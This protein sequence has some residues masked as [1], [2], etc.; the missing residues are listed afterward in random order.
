[1]GQG[2]KL[3]AVRAR[4]LLLHPLL[5]PNPTMS[6]LLLLLLLLWLWRS[7]RLRLLVL[8]YTTFPHTPKSLLLLQ[9]L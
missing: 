7:W 5:L 8:L 6:L 1:V 4:L 3:V 9:L 2:L